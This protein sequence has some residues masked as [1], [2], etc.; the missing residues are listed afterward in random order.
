MEN[1]WHLNNPGQLDRY[2]ETNEFGTRPLL[3]RLLLMPNHQIIQE[4]FEANQ[5]M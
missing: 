2:N 4:Q 5:Q 3:G 1:Y